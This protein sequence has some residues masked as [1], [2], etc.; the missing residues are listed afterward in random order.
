MQLHWWFQCVFVMWTDTQTRA[1]A[2]R[3]A[4]M[5]AW[6]DA[7]WFTLA[8]HCFSSHSCI[9]YAV[10]CA[11]WIHCVAL[12]CRHTTLVAFDFFFI[13]FRSLDADPLWGQ[14]LHPLQWLS[15]VAFKFRCIFVSRLLLRN[16]K[17]RAAGNSGD[18][19]MYTRGAALILG[20]VWLAVVLSF[21]SRSDAR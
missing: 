2:Y 11:V 4:I 19:Y 17:L 21:N 10:I 16:L 8:L 9:N 1:V 6:V 13:T 20:S 15:V 3:L 7:G 5:D 14:A 12:C 18:R